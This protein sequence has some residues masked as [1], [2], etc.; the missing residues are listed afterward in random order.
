MSVQT[1]RLSVYRSTT[2]PAQRSVG[3]S[4]RRYSFELHDVET[5]I[6][7]LQSPAMRD[8]HFHIGEKTSSGII[9]IVLIVLI[10]V[11]KPF[12]KRSG[13]KLDS[14]FNPLSYPCH[15]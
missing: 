7:T 10:V 14:A 12:G 13:I 15:Y 11:I 9:E 8:E 1:F 6:L 3:Q 4:H 2:F 5:S